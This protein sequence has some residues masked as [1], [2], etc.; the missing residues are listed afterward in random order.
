[1]SPYNATFMTES[2]PTADK[3]ALSDLTFGPGWAR[4]PPSN[5]P[6]QAPSREEEGRD[7]RRGGGGDRGTRERRRP[8]ARR[9]YPPRES[10]DGKPSRGLSPREQRSAP[11]YSSGR[12]TREFFRD[13]PVTID[14]LPERRGL[15]PLAHR[16]AAAGR[17]FSLFE[18]AGMFLSKPDYYTVRLTINPS[19]EG[20]NIKELFQCG[21][22]KALFLDRESATAHAFEQHFDR[23]YRREEID[24]EPPKGNFTCV[25]RCTVTGELLGP[26]NYHGYQERFTALHHARFAH[27]TSEEY[28]KKIENVHDAALVEQWKESMKRQAVYHSINASE[29]TPAL[30]R[31]ADVE[32]DFR[33]KHAPTMVHAGH[34]FV[35]PGTIACALDDQRLKATIRQAWNHETRFPLKLSIAI[36]LAFRRLGLHLFKTAD[37]STY[38]TSICPSPIDP[39]QAVSIVREILE[40]L[41]A[42]PGLTRGELLSALRPGISPDDPQLLELNK[43]IRW[44]VGKGHVIEFSNGKMTIPDASFLR[45]QHAR[46]KQQRPAV[47]NKGGNEK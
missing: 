36:R 13:I 22:C 8:E 25:A 39:V 2:L 15:A 19:T 41:M 33:E 16:L 23:F 18:V 1:M 30:T 28:G 32:K 29:G 31:I 20:E 45:V 21:E 46:R 3:E 43:A 42:H 40:Y 26:P 44:L 37:S 17:A 24:A 47:R 4:T 5:A 12:E 27:F 6:T 10:S 7:R 35:V 14:F 9:V 34:S 38:L 11:S